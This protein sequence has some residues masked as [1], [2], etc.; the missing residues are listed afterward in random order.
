[1]PEPARPDAAK[2]VAA[3]E[4]TPP[5][6]VKAPAPAKD[7]PNRATK[8]EA[9]VQAAKSSPKR[10]SHEAAPKAVASTT[11]SDS[12]ASE[13]LAD[14]HELYRQKRLQEASDLLRIAAS[15]TS[16]SEARRAMQYKSALYAKIQRALAGGMSSATQSTEA[17][18]TLRAAAGLDSN[19]GHAFEKE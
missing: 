13:P 8:R 1:P 5:T 10:P 18:E 15:S 16:D 3:P 4:A 17:F 6:S 2:A 12:K 11:A 9:P 7:E 14:A 19:A